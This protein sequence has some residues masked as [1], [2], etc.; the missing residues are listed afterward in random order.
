MNKNTS[1]LKINSRKFTDKIFSLNMKLIGFMYCKTDYLPACR[2]A[3]KCKK[4][5]SKNQSFLANEKFLLTKNIN[6]FKFYKYGKYKKKNRRMGMRTGVI[7]WSSLY[8]ICNW[9][10]VLLYIDCV[11]YGK[12]ISLKTYF[13][14]QDAIDASC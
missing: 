12:A 7:V 13:A 9:S 5:N 10:I 11:D 2:R 3:G 14:I 6:K 4:T 8:S 1:L